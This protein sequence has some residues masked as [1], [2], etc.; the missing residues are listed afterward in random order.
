MTEI[1]PI[2]F[3][4]HVFEFHVVIDIKDIIKVPSRVA[5]SCQLCPLRTPETCPAQTSLRLTQLHPR[6][7][8]PVTSAPYIEAASI[9]NSE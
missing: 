5:V 8:F 1:R 2:R 7:T 3:E 4:F 9:S 6:C